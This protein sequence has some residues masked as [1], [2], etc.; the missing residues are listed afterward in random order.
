MPYKG[1][2]LVAKYAYDAFGNCTIVQ[3]NSDDIANINPF[4]YRG[5]YYDI[6]SGL[7]YLKSRYYSPELG[8]FISP[9]GIEYLEPDNVLGLNLYAYCYNNPIMYVDSTGHFPVAIEIITTI[10]DGAMG[11][12]EF[13]LNYSLKYLKATPKITMKVAKKLAR[14]GGHIQSARQIIRNHQNLITST[15]Q[16]LDDVVMLSKKIGKVLLVA[17]VLWTIGA[18]YDSGDPNWISDSVVDVGISIGIYGLG[19]IPGVGWALA[20]GAVILTE[21][22]DNKIEEFK[23]WFANEW[24][25]FWSFSWI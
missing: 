1:F 13:G 25:E 22:F 6:E 12:Y 21:V 9:D 7:Y 14:K 24:N 5:Y 16:S 10:I 19:A 3:N 8:R 18:N 2:D 20:V 17:D 4:R 23:D 11:L 15:Q